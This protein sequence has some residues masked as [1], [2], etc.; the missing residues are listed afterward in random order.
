MTSFGA[1]VINTN[2]FNGPAASA[3][4]SFVWTQYLLAA[5]TRPLQHVRSPAHWC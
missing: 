4:R 5:P 3:A 2:P 1:Q